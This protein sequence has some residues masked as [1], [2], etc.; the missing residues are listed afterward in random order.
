MYPHE[1]GLEVCVTLDCL[2][3][4]MKKSYVISQICFIKELIFF[5][6]TSP[7]FWNCFHILTFLIFF[8]IDS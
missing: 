2:C 3:N 8:V 4:H 1:F 6:F 5:Y 7:Y